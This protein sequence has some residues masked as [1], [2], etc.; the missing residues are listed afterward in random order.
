MA[1]KNPYGPRAAEHGAEL[2]RREEA[3]LD[4]SAAAPAPLAP[5][6]S[7]LVVVFGIW[8]FLAIP[9]LNP[10]YSATG[11]DTSLRDEGIAAAVILCGFVLRLWPQ[12]RPAAAIAVLGGLALIASGL[13]A[14][15]DVT[16]TAVNEVISGVA[17][18]VAAV[19]ARAPR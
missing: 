7:T 15:H 11:W 6:G 17:V 13:W 2:T 16:R 14:D 12:N 4:A 10:P 19:L 5:I 18:A 8:V 9:V 1:T 3:I